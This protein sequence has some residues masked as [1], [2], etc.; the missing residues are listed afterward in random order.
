[1]EKFIKMRRK[2]GKDAACTILVWYSQ[3]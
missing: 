2:T 1:M 3:W